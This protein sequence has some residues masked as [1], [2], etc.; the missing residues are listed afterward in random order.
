MPQLGVGLATPFHMPS[1]HAT[2]FNHSF[3]DE[4]PFD[5][6]RQVKAKCT[7]CG[8]WTLKG[9]PCYFCGRRGKPLLVPRDNSVHIAPPGE[10][11][12]PQSARD[13]ARSQTR[14]QSASAPLRRNAAEPTQRQVEPG[15]TPPP[16]ARPPT[17]QSMQRP[18]PL[19]PKGY[20]NASAHKF[21]EESSY[22]PSQNAA[23][24][25]CKSCGCWASRGKP[26]SLCRT[27]TR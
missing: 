4:A 27:I 24:V 8:C 18:V 13:G 17:S 21:R 11:S 2:A 7:A 22:N 6:R 16:S 5:P 12:M 20:T 3:R 19:Q 9:K 14:S 23:K 15:A 1:N 25:K 10:G 26:C